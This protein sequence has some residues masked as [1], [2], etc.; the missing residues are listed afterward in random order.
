MTALRE[1]RTALLEKEARL[2]GT[3]AGELGGSIRA[4]GVDVAEPI[5]SILDHT[6]TTSWRKKK[7]TRVQ[8][9]MRSSWRVI[10]SKW[11]LW[12]W[13]LTGRHRG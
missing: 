9:A 3:A 8:T 1:E 13:R 6:S 2:A 7:L 12:P 11:R 10:R 5:S 4:A